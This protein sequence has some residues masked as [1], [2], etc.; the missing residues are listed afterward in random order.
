MG[1]AWDHCSGV[2]HLLA[3]KAGTGRLTVLAHR[4]SPYGLYENSQFG[5]TDCNWL[6]C[7][8][9]NSDLSSSSVFLSLALFCCLAQPF[10]LM[11]NTVVVV[12]VFKVLFISVFSFAWQ[13]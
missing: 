12:V 11:S 4:S 2:T 10:N 8:T 1:P 9:D 3:R 13:F 6:N 7:V 5:P